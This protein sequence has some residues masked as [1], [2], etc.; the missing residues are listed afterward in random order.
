MKLS[1]SPPW[2]KDEVFDALLRMRPDIK[3]LDEA[4]GAKYD[5]ICD[6]LAERYGISTNPSNRSDAEQKELDKIA[7]AVIK[8]FSKAV[9]DTWDLRF[10]EQNQPAGRSA[11]QGWTA[12]A[13]CRALPVASGGQKI[14][15]GGFP[16]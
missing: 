8:D 7:K 10:L 9:F 5:E 15:S 4:K 16:H 13:P 3:V 12:A 6:A 2:T 1:A 14:D 11:E